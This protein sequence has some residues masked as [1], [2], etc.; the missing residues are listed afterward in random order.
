MNVLD[1]IGGTKYLSLML[2]F[3]AMFSLTGCSN[4]TKQESNIATSISKISKSPWKFHGKVVR[5]S[6]TFNEC[7][8]YS[9]NICEGDTYDD[10]EKNICMGVSFESRDL[11][12]YVRYAT[13]TIEA[14]YDAS[15]AA[16]PKP[17]EEN[18]VV[19]AHRASQLRDTRVIKI[20]TRRAA[21]QGHISSYGLGALIVPDEVTANTLKA[22]FL[23]QLSP[24]VDV[25]LSELEFAYL[26]DISQ[27]SGYDEYKT[28]KSEGGVCLCEAGIGKCDKIWP[29]LE[30]HIWGLPSDNPYTCWHAQKI[31]GEW[32]YPIP[33]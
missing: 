30:G 10:S 18:I 20:I 14:D 9:C 19:C 3:A 25:K 11:E 15:C 2:F 4:T 6:G 24:I 27:F 26:M 21:S 8:S 7:K 33:Q 12:K 28:I 31:N 5:V 17:G 29:T 13:V 23:K 16:F 1:V 22:T 32:R